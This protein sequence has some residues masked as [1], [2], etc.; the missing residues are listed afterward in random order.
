[1]SPAALR[2]TKPC[3]WRCRGKTPGLASLLVTL[4][5]WLGAGPG[6]GPRPVLAAPLQDQQTISVPIN[7]SR[8]L[9]LRDFGLREPITRVSVAN[10]AIADILVINPKQ[11][12][13][14]GKE[15]G[16]HQHDPVG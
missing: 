11:L 12:Y 15:L 1:M 3:R 10:P 2:P 9:D 7:K 16:D 8:V 4:I 13:I 5:L 14:N 6:P